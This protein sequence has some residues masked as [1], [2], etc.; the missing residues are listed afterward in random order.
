MT[1]LGFSPAET[2][3][4]K[5]HGRTK[6]AE[7]TDADL[8]M[9]VIA[10][11]QFEPTIRIADIGVLVKDGVVTLNGTAANY[12][13]KLNAIV[14]VKRV[15]GVLAIA[16]DIE[17][18]LPDFDVH[19]DADIAAAVLNRISWTS[20]IPTGAVQVIV[21]GGQ[22][23][24]QGVV[25]WA[26]QKHAAGQAAEHLAGVLGVSNQITI[27]PALTADGIDLNLRAA[28]RRSALLDGAAI[29][30]N[31]QGRHVVLSG[32]VSSHAEWEEADR[33]AWASA[34]VLSVD[35]RLK[36][37]WFWDMAD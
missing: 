31:T 18:S 17:V 29:Q 2:P 13:E 9:H 5:G 24:L 35:N 1:E 12:G 37:Q 10:Q 6:A 21:R 7:M 15:A 36:V 34:G 23:E 27:R 8:K 26:Y 33:L 4:P 32:K 30:V 19:P 25:E 28:I 20:M 22:V 16:D 3:A 14:A 11:L